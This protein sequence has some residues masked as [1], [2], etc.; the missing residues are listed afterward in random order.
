MLGG[1]PWP[2]P[3]PSLPPSIPPQHPSPPTFSLRGAPPLPGEA[4]GGAEGAQGAPQNQSVGAE[5]GEAG[6]RLAQRTAR[7]Y[8][9]RPGSLIGSPL[10]SAA[11]RETSKEVSGA[12]G[13]G[14][15]QR[16]SSWGDQ[17]NGGGR[18]GQ[19]HSCAPGARYRRSWDSGR[20]S[21]LGGGRRVPGR[22]GDIAHIAHIV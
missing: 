15:R 16:K 21:A 9:C 8:R 10:A 2:C 17:A 11:K 22:D 13:A 3:V 12:G 4:E 18:R 19:L 14:G 6:H 20:T 1:A 7:P 5:R